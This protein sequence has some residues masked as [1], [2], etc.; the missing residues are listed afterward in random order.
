MQGK[1]TA[2]LRPCII[3]GGGRFARRKFCLLIIHS[4]SIH[5][6]I[7]V[8]MNEYRSNSQNYC[9]Q[10]CLVRVGPRCPQI[11]TV[12]IG[13]ETPPTNINNNYEFMNINILSV[14]SGPTKTGPAGPVPPWISSCKPEIPA[15]ATYVGMVM[16]RTM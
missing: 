9:T 15:A 8:C 11:E 14:K 16:Y 2:Q 12:K 1:Q 4:Q 3:R 10:N 6:R 5:G 7:R 13:D